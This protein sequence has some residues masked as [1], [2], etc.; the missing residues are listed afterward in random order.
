MG[1]PMTAADDAVERALAEFRHE[2]ASPIALMEAALRELDR[3]ADLDGDARGLVE[4]AHRQAEVLVQLL[5]RLRDSDD[6]ADLVADPRP[7]DLGDLVAQTVSD[8]RLGML[9]GRDCRVA[10]DDVV[11]VHVDGVLL[12]RALTNLLDNAVKY[13]PDDTIIHVT[14]ERDGDEATVWVED[15]G[16]GVAPEDQQR[17]FRRFERRN[18]DSQGLGLGLAIVRRVVEVHGGTVRALPAPSGGG[19]RFVMALPLADVTA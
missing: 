18:E 9:D 15:Q 10:T 11:P 16:D 8:L 12:R 2:A 13:S 7:H 1:F 19:T 4:V 5:E 6:Q 3:H 17:I 14:A